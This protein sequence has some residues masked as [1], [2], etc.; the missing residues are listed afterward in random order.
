MT[1]KRL[2]QARR[3]DDGTSEPVTVKAS[4]LEP[5]AEGE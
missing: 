1:I 5:L 3:F 4:D 2:R